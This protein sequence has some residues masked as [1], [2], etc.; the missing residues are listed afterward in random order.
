[1]TC[2]RA[3][4]RCGDVRL[5]RCERRRMFQSF[6]AESDPSLGRERV[7]RLREWLAARRLDGFIVPRADEHQGEYVAPRSERLR[8][9][10]GFSGSAGVAIVLRDR[11]RHLRRRPL[12]AAGA[13]PDRPASLHDREPD[14][15]PAAEMDQGQSRQG[16]PARLRPLAAHDRRRQ[17]ADSSGRQGRRELVPLAANPIDQ[18][19]T[20]RPPPP[21]RRS[22][23]IRSNSPASS[24]RISSRGSPRRSP[25]KARRMRC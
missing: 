6:D 18:L 5:S 20:D 7:A 3:L 14:R 8:W 22:R 11:A 10:T 1:M 2:L 21:L 24:P 12:H 23:S 19:W 4:T 25:R 16:R 13:R 15:Q 9:L 17:G